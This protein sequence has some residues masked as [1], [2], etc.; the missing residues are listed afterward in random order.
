M[1]EEKEGK[2]T[3]QRVPNSEN[4][5]IFHALVE[6]M[7]KEEEKGYKTMQVSTQTTTV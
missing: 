1:E 7:V 3:K 2:D 4:Y 5:T 6:A